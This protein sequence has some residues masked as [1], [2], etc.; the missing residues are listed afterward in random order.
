[1]ALHAIS[2]LTQRRL[3]DDIERHR[4]SAKL[5]VMPP[6]CPLGTQPIDFDHAEMLID[7]ALA[8]AREFLDSGGEDRPPIRMQMHR[9][10]SA[11]EPLHCSKAA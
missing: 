7:R 8:D 2:L 3:I 10:G 1:M 6:P 9:H 5:I 4:G 11:P